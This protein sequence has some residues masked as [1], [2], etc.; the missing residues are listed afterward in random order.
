M[1]KTAVL[2]VAF[3]EPRLIKACINQ[4]K[5]PYLYDD[6]FHLVMV[7]S[8]PWRGTWQADDTVDI[9]TALDPGYVMSNNWSDQASQF[10]HGLNWLRSNGY[11]WAIIC[12][13]DEFYTQNSIRYLLKEIDECEYEALKAPHMFVYWRNDEYRITPKQND[14]PII[15]IRTDKRFVSKRHADV[16]FGYSEVDMHHFSYVRDDVEMLK[17]I[18]SF[19]HNNEFDIQNWYQNVWLK[20]TPDMENLHPVVPA[21]FKKAIHAPAPLPITGLWYAA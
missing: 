14:S 1:S 6:V 7:S 19:E 12:D 2:T 20:W 18:Q 16:F 11:D 15:A 5:K 21:Q 9:A 17:K 8:I 3:N 4:F 13:A 10:N